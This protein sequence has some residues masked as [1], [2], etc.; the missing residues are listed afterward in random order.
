MDVQ[1]KASMFKPDFDLESVEFDD[2]FS[3]DANVRYRYMI[4]KIS[5]T[6]Y[7]YMLYKKNKP[8]VYKDTDN[9]LAMLWQDEES[10]NYCRENDELFA[11]TDCVKVD[12]DSVYHELLS[13][14]HKK[15]IWVSVYLN[16]EDSID[17]PA[18]EFK[19]E[20]FEYMFYDMKQDWMFDR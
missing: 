15:N 3:A 12:I 2:V 7:V 19:I 17:M 6:G 9:R 4:S 13:D 20:W 10:C 18:R 16:L 11:N 8:F 1:L 14:F 5:K